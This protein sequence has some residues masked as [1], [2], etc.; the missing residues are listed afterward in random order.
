MFLP[1]LCIA[2]RIEFV[3]PGYS[4]ESVLSILNG[5]GNAMICEDP[6]RPPESQCS[7]L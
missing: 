5:G 1:E 4:S 7:A 3:I 2:V 6:D